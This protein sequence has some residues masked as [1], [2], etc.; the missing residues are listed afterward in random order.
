MVPADIGTA[1]K[2]KVEQR[3][4]A[5]SCDCGYYMFAILQFLLKVP[6]LKELVRKYKSQCKVA[7]APKEAVIPIGSC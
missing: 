7:L 6:E 4:I 5:A 3:A 1:D 2:T